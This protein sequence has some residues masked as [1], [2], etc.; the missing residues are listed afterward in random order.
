MK[1]S[2]QKVIWCGVLDTWEG[3]VVA[4]STNRKQGKSGH[5]LGARKLA[6]R[7]NK[8][9]AGPDHKGLGGLVAGRS[10][11]RFVP[12]EFNRSGYFSN[13][14]SF[15]VRNMYTECLDFVQ[16]AETVKTI[17]EQEAKQAQEKIE[18]E[19]LLKI[20]SFDIPEEYKVILREDLLRNY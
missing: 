20:E 3:R 17:L 18:K 9:N 1:K 2:D 5:G 16:M 15:T 8:Y 7:L 10:F 13:Y 11:Y 6:Q 14:Y 12:F 4:T 19:E